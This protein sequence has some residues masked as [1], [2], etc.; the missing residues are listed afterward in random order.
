MSLT[1]ESTTPQEVKKKAGLLLKRK[2]HN[3]PK[4]GYRTS[5]DTKFH[6]KMPE[7][8]LGYKEQIPLYPRVFLPLQQ[9]IPRQIPARR[10]VK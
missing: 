9:Y 7:S 1:I 5:P 8:E 6:E 4:N 2:L 10:A 3:L